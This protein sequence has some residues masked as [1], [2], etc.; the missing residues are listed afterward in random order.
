MSRP[1]PLLWI[2]Y[3]FTG[4]LGPRYREWVLHDVTCRT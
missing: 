1:N 3:T 2:W 4:K